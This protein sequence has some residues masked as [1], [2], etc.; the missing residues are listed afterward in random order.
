M[1][2]G[3]FSRLVQVLLPLRRAANDRTLVDD[4]TAT[5]ESTELLGRP[6]LPLSLEGTGVSITVCDIDHTW[7]TTEACSRPRLPL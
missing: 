2:G 6:H 5:M 4:G 3:P 7:L 1:L